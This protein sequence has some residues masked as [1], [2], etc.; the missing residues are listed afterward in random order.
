M[1]VGCVADSET[2][3]EWTVGWRRRVK[4]AESVVG[5]DPLEDG[6]VT[7][8]GSRGLRRNE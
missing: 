5:R 1:C 6:K 8:E 7:R 4:E 3:E 2:G